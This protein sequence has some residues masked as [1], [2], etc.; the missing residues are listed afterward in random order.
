MKHEHIQEIDSYV[1]IPEN[2]KD[3]ILLMQSD[4]YRCYARKLSLFE[5]YFKTFFEPSLKFLFWFRLSQVDGWLKIIAKFRRRHYAFKYGIM[6]PSSTKIG[7]GFFIGHP[8]V[9]L[10]I[11]LQLLAIMSM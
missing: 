3:A 11:I 7:Y 4:F 2:Y 9:S 6:I 8:L 5:M 10:L 1:P